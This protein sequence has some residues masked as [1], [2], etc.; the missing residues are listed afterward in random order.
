[1]EYYYGMRIRPFDIGCQPMDGFLH[2]V[3]DML[4]E[5]ASR[6]YDVLAYS[7]KLTEEETEHYSLDYLGKKDV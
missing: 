3:D 4:P 5:Q 1:M 7:R 6:Y 2:V